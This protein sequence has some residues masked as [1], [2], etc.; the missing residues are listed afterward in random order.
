LDFLLSK[1]AVVKIDA[2]S[3]VAVQ[4]KILCFFIF[5]FLK[6]KI[7][8]WVGSAMAWKTSYCIETHLNAQRSGRKYMC[9]F[10]VAQICGQLTLVV[11]RWQKQGIILL[12]KK[13][14]KKKT[15]CLGIAQLS[16]SFT[17]TKRHLCKSP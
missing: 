17:S 13:N 10:S 8:L 12:P 11:V 16:L 9:N 2:A 5:C 6:V 14:E 4:K 3:I 7:T 15:L 1:Q